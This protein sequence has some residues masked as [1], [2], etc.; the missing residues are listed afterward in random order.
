MKILH[1]IS[2]VNPEGG[3]PIEGIVQLGTALMAAGHLV[4]VTSLDPPDAIYL[5]QCSLPV[6]ALG[7]ATRNYAFG[8]RL[9]PWLRANRRQYDAVVVNGLWQFHSF[10]AWQALATPARLTW[11]LPMACLIPGSRSSI[12]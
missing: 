7:P 11:C 2:S 1:L 6:Y 12:R 8:N 10:G 4:E 5:R 9:V 3:G